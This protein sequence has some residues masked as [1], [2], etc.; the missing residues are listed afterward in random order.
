MANPVYS[1]F[2]IDIS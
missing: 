2:I 1:K